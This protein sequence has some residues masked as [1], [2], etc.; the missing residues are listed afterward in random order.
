MRNRAITF[1]QIAA[2]LF[3]LFFELPA[4]AQA[5]VF[6]NE[7]FEGNLTPNWETLSCGAGFATG[8]NPATSTDI[9][10]NGTHSLKGVYNHAGNGGWIDRKYPATDELYWRV[11]ERFASGWIWDT[12][13]QVK[14][15]NVGTN[16][17]YPNF[18]VMHV[19]GSPHLTIQAQIPV[20]A[21][22][23]GDSNPYGNGQP[24]DACRYDDKI[25]TPEANGVWYCLEGHIKMN[26][27]GVADGVI[28][29]WTNGTLISSFSGRTFRGA[30]VSGK[31]GNSSLAT[32]EFI[33]V[34]VQ[35]EAA[36]GVR[37]Y[38]DLAVGNTR[39]GC[40][41]QADSTAP[42]APTGV[43]IQ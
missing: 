42:T 23:T 36:T 15:F 14:G 37:Y 43:K 13:Q 27:P 3:L 30:A 31:N 4:P 1:G 21:C 12:A 7:T 41:T 32:F 16:G 33:R 34:Y 24:Y 29:R 11:W 2:L 22:A 10:V 25:S 8:C 9:A 6:W 28:E 35:G 26:T 19:F 39:I 20:E 40:G 17:V 5:V 38:D 18:W